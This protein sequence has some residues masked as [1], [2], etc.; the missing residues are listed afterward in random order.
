[1]NIHL[2]TNDINF[3]LIIPSIKSRC[4]NNT[5]VSLPGYIVHRQF[6][7]FFKHNYRRMNFQ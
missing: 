3:L 1:M 4:S 6:Y 7:D 2:C 5:H